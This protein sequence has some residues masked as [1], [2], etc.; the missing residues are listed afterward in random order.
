MRDIIAAV[1]DKES[2]RIQLAK[3]DHE[4]EREEIRNKNL[5]N[6]NEMRISLE[7]KRDELEKAFDLVTN[8]AAIFVDVAISMLLK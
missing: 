2:D 4:T 5:E 1:D 7:S 6:I 8:N 3:Q